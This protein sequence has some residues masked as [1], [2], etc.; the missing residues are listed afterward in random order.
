MVFEHLERVSE[1]EPLEPLEPL[2]RRQ[3]R[4][5]DSQG[6]DQIQQ[7]GLVHSEDSCGGCAVTVGM[8]ERFL[9]DLRSGSIHGV[10]I[11]KPLGG[12]FHA[13]DGDAQR[14][15]FASYFR[16]VTQN[17]SAFDHVGQLPDVSGPG[18]R[19]ELS[20]RVRRDS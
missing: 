14:Q 17:G 18:I 3:I 20:F 12:V 4:L 5:F 15:I 13:S 1:H 6:F 16:P 10:T 19:N 8:I 11:G 2:E 9:D 7:V